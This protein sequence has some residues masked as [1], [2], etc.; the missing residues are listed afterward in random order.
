MKKDSVKTEKWGSK[1]QK[2]S[3]CVQPWP[4]R[5]T[6]FEDSV[7]IIKRVSEL[8]HVGARIGQCSPEN[9]ENMLFVDPKKKRRGVS[10]V[11]VYP[12]TPFRLQNAVHI[13]RSTTNFRP[14]RQT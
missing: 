9:A 5:E 6:I 13:I 2:L 12:H 3:V 4:R 14:V 10:Q 8:A 11:K 1:R 7:G